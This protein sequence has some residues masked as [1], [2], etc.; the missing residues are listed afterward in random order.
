[1][2]ERQCCEEGEEGFWGTAAEGASLSL[3]EVTGL[4]EAESLTLY[5]KEELKLGGWLSVPEDGRRK[6]VMKNLI[7]FS[8]CNHCDALAAKVH[9]H[10]YCEEVV[11][12]HRPLERRT[13]EFSALARMLEGRASRSLRREVLAHWRD[14]VDDAKVQAKLDKIEQENVKL[15][16]KLKKFVNFLAREPR[17]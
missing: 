3:Q 11:K 15:K 14:V 6:S 1:M 12:H 17:I 4:A 16:V 10:G 13:R 2:F 9:S 5:E 7:D 8:E